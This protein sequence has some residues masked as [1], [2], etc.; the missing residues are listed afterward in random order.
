[1]TKARASGSPL[2]RSQATTVSRWFV[3][4]IAFTLWRVTLAFESAWPMTSRVLF[5][6]S[7]G[8]CSTQPACGKIC[9]CSSWPVETM[10]PAWSKRMARVEVVPW[11]MAMT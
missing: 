10:L 7:F 9:S 11:S 3:M 2:A 5:Q 4:P 8:S 6:I 1:M